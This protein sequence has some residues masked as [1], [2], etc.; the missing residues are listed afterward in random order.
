MHV[1][2]KDAL[3]LAVGLIPALVVAGAAFIFVP[4]SI[5]LYAPVANQLPV[6]TRFVFS[7]Y[8]LCALLPVLVLCIWYFWRNPIWRG[9]A[10]AAFGVVSSAVVV[11]LGWWA[12]FQPGLILQLI[13]QS[14][15]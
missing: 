3:L 6:Q 14:A 7:F 11:A 2:R 10:A 12:V 4:S 15:Q 5:T 13:R 1:R 8:F 9:P